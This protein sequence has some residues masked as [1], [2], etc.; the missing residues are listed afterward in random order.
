[1]NEQLMESFSECKHLVIQNLEKSQIQKNMFYMF[2]RENKYDDYVK[3]FTVNSKQGI[4][5]I[6]FK[7]H[8][9][10]EEFCLQNNFRSKIL[11]RP[12]NIYFDMNLEERHIKK[13]FIRGVTFE[14][15]R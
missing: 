6:E 5:R 12:F 13:F 10:A 8:G 9:Q 4:I 1:M 7:D 15:Q 14:N 2:L 11:Q 3:E